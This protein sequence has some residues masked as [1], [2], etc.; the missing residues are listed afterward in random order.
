MSKSSL[1]NL[2]SLLSLLKI[3]FNL[4]MEKEIT[5]DINVKLDFPNKPLDFY[6][7]EGYK[8]KLIKDSDLPC[9][10]TK[11]NTIIGQDCFKRYNFYF[12]NDQEIILSIA[13]TFQIIN[14]DTKDTTIYHGTETMGIGVVTV[15]PEKKYF[16]IGECGDFPNIYI[17]EYPSMKTYRILRKG[18][19]RVYSALSFNSKGDLLGSVGSD[20]D[21]NLVI[22]NWV[23]ETIVLKAKAFSQEIFSCYFSNNIEGKLVTSGVGHIKFWEMARTFTGLK[24]QGELGKFGQVELSDISAFVEYPDGK[25]L[26]GTEYGT[27]LLWEGI[28]I[29]AHVKLDENTPLHNGNIDYMSWEGSDTILS[30]GHDGYLKWWNIAVL[31]NLIID[32]NNLAFAKPVKEVLLTN[33]TTGKPIKIINLVKQANFWLIKDGNGYFIRVYLTEND[34]KYEVLYDFHSGPIIK[35][36]ML[37]N[38]P[39]LISQGSDSKTFIYNLLNNDKLVLEKEYLLTCSACDICPRENDDNVVI[40]LGYENGLFRAFQL[41]SDK[42]IIEPVFQTKAHEEAIRRVKFSHDKTNLITVTQHEVFLFIIAELNNFKPLWFIRKEEKIVDVDWHPDSAHILIGLA[43]GVVEEI[44]VPMAY[45]NSNTFLLKDYKCKTFTIKLADS[46]L[47]KDDERKRKKKDTKKKEEPNPAPILNCRY[48]NLYQTGDFLVTAQKPFNE[49]LYLCNFNE[50]N[51]PK[52]RPINFWR[53]PPQDNYIKYIS[54]KFIILANNK[55]SI[56]I[57]HKKLLDHYIELFPNS[58][59]VRSVALSTDQNILVISYKDGTIITYKLLKDQL[60][61]YLDCLIQPDSESKEKTIREVNDYL[62]NADSRFNYEQSDLISYIKTIRPNNDLKAIDN[63]EDGMISLEKG[64][65]YNEEIAK[66]KKAEDVKN[67]SRARIEKIRHEFK[68]VS[69]QNNELFEEARLRPHELIVDEQYTEHMRKRCEESLNDIKH[70]YDY[71]KAKEN[72]SI[73]KINTFF[74][75]SVKTAKFYVF[76]LQTKDFVTSIRCPNLP[77]GF[78]ESIEEMEDKLDA[79]A[80]RL[81]FDTLDESYSKYLLTGDERNENREVQIQSLLEKINQNLTEYE[82]GESSHETASKFNKDWIKNELTLIESDIKELNKVMSEKNDVRKLVNDYKT[83]Q[84]GNLNSIPD[85]E[86]SGSKIRCPEAYSLKAALDRYL[87]EKSMKIVL[88]FQKSIYDYLNRIHD[89]REQFNDKVRSLRTKKVQLIS[90]LKERKKELEKINDNLGVT[91]KLDWLDYE[92]LEQYE[93]PENDLKVKRADLDIYVYERARKERDINLDLFA[94]TQPEANE[95]SDNV[96]K[97]FYAERKRK[98]NETPL[99]AEYKQLQAIKLE[100]RKQKI[101]I[102]CRKKIKDFDEEVYDL[103]KEQMEIHFKQKLGELELLVKMEEYGIIRAHDSDDQATLK[104]LEEIYHSYEDNLS[105]I[106]NAQNQ[107]A[108]TENALKGSKEARDFIIKEFEQCIAQ[109]KES[110]SK[111]E[112]LFYQ[113]V[114]KIEIKEGS[115]TITNPNDEKVEDDDFDNEKPRAVSSQVWVQIVNFRM[116]KLKSEANIERDEKKLNEHRIIFNNLKKAKFELDKKLNDLRDKINMDERKK[117]RYLN[118]VEIAVPL[119]LDKFSKLEAQ[120]EIKK[121]YLKLS[122]DISKGIIFTKEKLFN[123]HKLYK[124]IISENKMLAKGISTFDEKFKLMENSIKTIEKQKVDILNKFNNEQILKFGFIINFDA[125]LDAT[126]STLADKLENEYRVLKKEADRQV[127]EYNTKIDQAK[128]EL[129]LETK[130]NT[131]KLE[132]IK[133]LLKTNQAKDK[134]LEGKNSELSVILL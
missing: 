6:Y 17:Y 86:S 36:Q 39:Y 43:T 32:D 45:D 78:Q 34:F 35:T 71:L 125:L 11:F 79:L 96:S 98:I 128:A 65:K 109:E 87:N 82:T 103:K 70:K 111:L 20:P 131:E 99:D 53:L 132:I 110:K 97:F 76:A 92:C 2:N 47:D 114:K 106:T 57:R 85:R 56:Q 58:V 127:D 10:F 8:E 54:Q 42:L 22:W 93:F 67:K 28:F 121:P 24:L 63:K 69:E 21:Y 60:E 9:S 123:L 116:D 62:A 68:V 64:R 81:D 1:E 134:E 119:K 101:I 4:K 90:E 129:A 38:T 94:K 15:H 75:D 46:Q 49:F 55:G 3:L 113:K 13:N 27:F 50:H 61:K 104:K 91:E 30:G 31:D 122:S 19:E 124:D 84:A 80:R 112:Q 118:L 95:G 102:E 120:G 88:N 77:P 29:K 25:V 33:P 51:N 52:L 115:Q 133:G 40:G 5:T 73:T 26:S 126:K 23:N 7:P 18:T 14:I 89:E 107:M 105:S 108:L 59:A 74:I 72:V 16:A 66:L 37:M 117:I 48:V 83:N 100:R 41:N 130:K 12:L 44:E